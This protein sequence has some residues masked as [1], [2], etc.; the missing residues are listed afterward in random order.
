[1][2][3]IKIT[4]P[5]TSATKLKTRDVSKRTQLLF[6]KRSSMSRKSHTL[7][8]F[9]K[10]QKE[11]TDSSMRDFTDWVAICVADMEVVNEAG[12]VRTIFSILRHLTSTPKPPPQNLTTD[13]AG[14]LLKSP[15]EQSARW[16]R[17]LKAKFAATE[18]ERDR[19]PLSPIPPERFPEDNLTRE[20]FDKSVN[21]MP[22]GKAVGPDYVPAEAF[23]SQKTLTRP[24]SKL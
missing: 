20:E 14:E 21:K 3:Q 9:K 16:Y 19:P 18:A 7:V 8:E 10:V 5:N 15:E 24:C 11:I 6:D 2:R 23:N 17:F 4:L 13:E 12:N 22:N 1:M